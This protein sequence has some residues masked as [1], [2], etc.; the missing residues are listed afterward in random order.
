MI[1]FQIIA[2]V[3]AAA[4]LL[5]VGER[6]RQKLLSFRTTCSW[7]LIWAAGLGLIW[8]PSSSQFLADTLGIGRG[9][10][11]VMY[12]VLA[13]LLL[14]IFRLYVKIELLQRDIT[15]V[16]RRNSLEQ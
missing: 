12:C 11:L 9:V 3:F 5:M 4:A 1:I 2:T 10:D 14:M 15:R 8:F 6:Y 16:V 13:F 7:M